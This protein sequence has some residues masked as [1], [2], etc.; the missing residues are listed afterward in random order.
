MEVARAGGQQAALCGL[1]QQP[2]LLLVVGDVKHLDAVQPAGE[3][4]ERA[5]ASLRRRDPRTGAPRRPRRRRG[6]SRSIAS[7]TVGLE[8][9]DVA[10]RAR[11]QIAREE[12]VPPCDPL[13]GQALARWPGRTSIASARCGRPGRARGARSP[14]SSSSN[15]SPRSRSAM[16]KIRRP[17]SARKSSSVGEQLR[18]GVVDPVA[19][20]VEVLVAA[21]DGAQL[22]GGNVMSMP[23][24]RAASS[25]SAT[26][27]TVSWSVSASRCHA[28][29]GGACTTS[30]G[31][32]APSEYVGVGLEVERWAVSEVTHRL[33]SLPGDPQHRRR[34]TMSTGAIIAI[35]VVAVVLL[36]LLAF[37]MP[38]MRA[39]ARVQERERELQHR[40]ERVAGRAPAE[41]PTLRERQAER[42][43]ARR[44]RL[45]ER[46]A[47]ARARPGRAPRRACGPARARHGRRRA[48]R[49]P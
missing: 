32:S 38:R 21:A 34:F 37:V 14:A 5:R 4:V 3:L 24:S 25:A 39:C 13:G 2:R 48:D 16:A 41:Q 11:D 43:R 26:P 31:A 44:A 1:R 27:S 17:R 35:V 7:G 20:D 6:G 46:E 8:R 40:R 49:R 47:E 29:R 12:L 15:P 19:E 18:V 45:A 22:D 33:G 23:C 10:R 36:S 30:R 28:G 9:R 42:G